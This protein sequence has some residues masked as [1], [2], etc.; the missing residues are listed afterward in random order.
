L[1]RKTEYKLKENKNVAKAFSLVQKSTSHKTLE[2][3]PLSYGILC[4][5]LHFCRWDTGEDVGSRK[6]K[7]RAA[8]WFTCS[9]YD[10]PHCR[11]S[12]NLSNPYDLCPKSPSPYIHLKK[13]PRKFAFPLHQF[14]Y[15]YF[16][17]NFPIS[18]A[19]TPP[20]TTIVPLI[21]DASPPSK[22]T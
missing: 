20:G 11:T 22:L 4:S 8:E 19:K 13:I 2:R 5:V 21:G 6:E 3:R 14:S 10:L 18:T 7:C 9:P 17:S 16:P 12:K 15:S 1:N